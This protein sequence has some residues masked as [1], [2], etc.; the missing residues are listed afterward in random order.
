MGKGSWKISFSV[1]LTATAKTS[2]C[3]FTREEFRKGRRSNKKIESSDPN[4]TTLAGVENK[5]LKVKFKFKNAKLKKLR[6]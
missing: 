3:K 1:Q 5:P 2:T 6:L 4:I